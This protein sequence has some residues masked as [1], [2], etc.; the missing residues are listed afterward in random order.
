MLEDI[1]ISD[2]LLLANK[3]EC[4]RYVIFLANTINQR[5]R[6][7]DIAPKKGPGGRIYFKPGKEIVQPSAEEVRERQSLC[8]FLAYFYVRIF[9]ILGSL[10]LTLIDDMEVHVKSGDLRRSLEE[11]DESEFRLGPT[12]QR[13]LG[14]PGVPIRYGDETYIGK[15]I[16]PYNPAGYSRSTYYKGGALP[17]NFDFLEDYV[18]EDSERITSTRKGYVFK[19]SSLRMAFSP[20]TSTFFGNLG[21]LLV[22]TNSDSY[23][24]Y[25]IALESNELGSNRYRVRLD[26]VKYKDS[27]KITKEE[28]RRILHQILDKQDA[29][30]ERN[31]RGKW[32]AREADGEGMDLTDFLSELKRRIDSRL[33]IRRPGRQTHHEFERGE[34]YGEHK[35]YPVEAKL[36][37]A[38]SDT[39]PA[40]RVGSMLKALRSTQPLGHCIARGLQ[41]LGTQISGPEFH[42]AA[43]D[44]R[45]HLVSN[46]VDGHDRIR[47]AIPRSGESIETI[48]GI[49]SLAQLFYD[50][51]QIKNPR[52]MKSKEPKDVENYVNSMKRLIEVFELPSKESVPSSELELSKITDRGSEKVCA[53][54]G[55]EDTDYNIKTPKGKMILTI[56]RQLFGSQIVHAAR[57]GKLLQQLFL[58]KKGVEGITVRLNPVVLTKGFPELDRINREARGV[59]VDYYSRCEGLYKKGLEVFELAKVKKVEQKEE[60]GQQAQQQGILQ[61]KPRQQQKTRKQVT[62]A[63]NQ[64]RRR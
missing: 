27:Q 26:G 9:Q 4:A 11:D 41:L 29:L 31:S 60:Q 17:S 40:L 30:I 48:P 10:M 28:G 25:E 56:V 43:C 18:R 13:V 2:F 47:D 61:A 62:F 21:Y 7:L 38:E 51:V 3:H 46:S 54:L 52:I 34:Y 24:I 39:D 42:S 22:G 19:N 5:F 20:G 37:Q 35:R 45:F 12:Q 58:I 1:N 15:S 8:I 32:V 23:P 49:K 57:C 63:N 16:R 33:D 36:K 64:T 6:V 59:L 44:S 55:K 50:F 14:A 53:T